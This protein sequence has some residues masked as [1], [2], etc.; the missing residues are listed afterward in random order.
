MCITVKK[1]LDIPISW[2]K[3]RKQTNRKAKK[4]IQE[5]LLHYITSDMQQYFSHLEACW[6]KFSSTLNET[7]LK[8]GGH[9]VQLELQ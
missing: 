2:C 8:L 6:Y 5:L 4:T 9:Y 7:W 1:L 3:I